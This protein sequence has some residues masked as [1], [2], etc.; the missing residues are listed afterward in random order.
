M[1]DRLL[2][3]LRTRGNDVDAKSPGRVQPRILTGPE[4]R[5]ASVFELDDINCIVRARHG[6]FLAN[7]FDKYL[8]RALINY[9]EYG[10]L[11]HA[12]VLSLLHPGERVVEVGANIGSHTV[13][14][15]KTVGPGGGVVAIE[16]QPSI[17]R[18][19]CANLALNALANVNPC[20]VACGAQRGII[21][22]PL[23]D[24][25]L[26][27]DHNSGGVSLGESDQGLPV[28][29]V[30]LDEMLDPGVSIQLMKVDVEGMELDVL[31]GAASLIGRHR[32]LLYVENDRPAK[33]PPLVEWV[34]Q[35]GYRPWMHITALFNP[36]NYFGMKENLYGDVSSFNMICIPK[37]RP[38]VP[39]RGLTEITDPANVF[40]LD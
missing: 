27:V 8:G 36:D 21:Q 32:P 28:S 20:A 13:G 4:R 7:R 23:L 34:M 31:R 1:F 3:Q 40:K 33:S 22:V 35:A 17:F 29:V 37:E 2:R 25:N 10:E 30:P 15:A 12:F 26:P 19:L 38:D 14:I 39:T 5:A 18:V 9:G 6:W 16:P 24:Y 11:E